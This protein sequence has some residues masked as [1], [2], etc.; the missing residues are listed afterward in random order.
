MSIFWAKRLSLFVLIILTVSACSAPQGE[1][2]PIIKEYQYKA[3]DYIDDGWQ[4]GH[5]VDFGFEQGKINQLINGIQDKTYPGIDSL[6]IVR[7]NTLV[8][9]ENFRDSFSEYDDWLGNEQLDVHIMHST[10]KSFVSALIGIAVQQGYINDIQAPFYQFFDYP[11]YQNPDFRKQQIT[12]EHVLT[13]QLGL[14]WD[15][16][17]R[18]FGDPDNSLTRL[19][20]NSQD[21]VKAL[22]DL[23]M[24]DS[25][26]NQYAYNTAATIALGQLLENTTG[27]KLE[28]YA[29]EYLF[30]PLQIESA[31]WLD[32]PT[33]LANGGSG[34]FLK[35]RDM[36]KFGQLYLDHG[37]WNGLQVIDPE[38]VELSLK[39]HVKLEWDYTSGYG[40]QWWLG[41]FKVDE[42]DIQFYSTRGSGGQ[43]I[44]IIPEFEMVVAFTAQNYDPTLYDS[45]FKL[46]ETFILGAL[47]H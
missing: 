31:R 47:N 8:L 9:H 15:E 41:E 46:V 17:T 36:A 37:S 5:L 45:P 10:S 7:N 34:L 39:Q 27:I 33:G 43:F 13:M 29:E 22:L 44:I 20:Q 40:F 30:S 24:V 14:E 1:A 38:W 28:N 25:P 35:T 6:S 12:L 3:P 42:K 26:G 2:E 19:A 16:W 32:T 21:Y 4:T 18:L 11:E 23:P